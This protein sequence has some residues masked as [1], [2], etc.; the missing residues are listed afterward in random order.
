[1]SLRTT[2]LRG[3]VALAGIAVLTAAVGTTSATAA[4]TS[5]TARKPTIVLVH[6]WPDT[7]GNAVQVVHGLLR[8]YPGRVVWL[9]S[10]PAADLPPGLAGGAAG[11]VTSVRVNSR[12][13]VAAC[14]IASTTTSTSAASAPNI[15]SCARAIRRAW[16]A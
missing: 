2:V 12:R 13:A 6:G 5:P 14:T 3:A 1:M 11:R 16:A 4:P 9:R 8:R 15:L 7:E 10:G